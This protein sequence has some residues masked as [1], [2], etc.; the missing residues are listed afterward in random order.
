M[1]KYMTVGKLES[2]GNDPCVRLSWTRSSILEPAS[3]ETHLRQVVIKVLKPGVS[4]SLSRPQF[5][6]PQNENGISDQRFSKRGSWNCEGAR[7]T[8]RAAYF[9]RTK[10]FS[11]NTIFPWKNNGQRSQSTHFLKNK[12]SVTSRKIIHVICCQ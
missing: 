12:Q 6:H 4:Y 1:R 3:W 7:D 10:L 8:L 9:H 2:T 5:L 11:Q